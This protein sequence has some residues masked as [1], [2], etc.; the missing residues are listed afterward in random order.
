M[1]IV[2]NFHFKLEKKC[3]KIPP[4]FCSILA[5][6]MHMKLLFLSLGLVFMVAGCT[7]VDLDEQGYKVMLISAERA[8][9]CEKIGSV[10]SSVVDNIGPIYRSEKKVQEELIR[11]AR[12]DAGAIGGDAIA[13]ATEEWNGEQS[14]NVYR[15]N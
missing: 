3:A 6:K 12:N 13:P 11:L 14:F 8:Q 9:S 4:P 1:E 2:L 7:W 15:C 5:K 10:S